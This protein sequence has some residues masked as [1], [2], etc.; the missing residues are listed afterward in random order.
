M[1]KYNLVVPLSGKGQR[2]VDGGFFLPKPM[3]ICGNKSILE[4]SMDSIDT[5]ECQVTFVVRQEHV[6]NYSIDSWLKNKF[7]HNIKIV[8]TEKATSGA[9]ETV[10]IGLKDLSEDLPLVVYCPDTT[11][12]PCYKPC[13]ED[14]KNDGLILTFKSNSPNYS[15]VQLNEQG[16][17]ILTKEKEVL[18][19]NLASVGVYCFKTTRLFKSYAEDYINKSS[20]ETHICPLYNELLKD[21]CERI[22]PSVITQRSIEKIHIMGTPEEFNFFESVSYRY[23]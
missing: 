10:L 7:G 1:V 9:T 2:M 5:S 20:K 8:I 19:S 6:K 23:F 21:N 13:D 17:V 14:F 18:P 15:Y 11:F 3:L 16:K 22:F 12:S 4:W